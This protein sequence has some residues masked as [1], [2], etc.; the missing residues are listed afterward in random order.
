MDHPF[1]RPYILVA[2]RYLGIS[3][4]TTEIKK[5][6]VDFPGEAW[7]LAHSIRNGGTQLRMEFQYCFSYD[8]LY[9]HMGPGAWYDHAGWI[10][11]SAKKNNP[12]TK[13]SGYF[14]P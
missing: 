9:Y 8:L 13:S 7:A 6:I 5:R 14:R 4:R 11:T 10:N 2:G 1:L 3:Y 12:G